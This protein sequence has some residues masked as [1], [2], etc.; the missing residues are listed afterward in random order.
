[1]TLGQKLRNIRDE[2]RLSVNKSLSEW[3]DKNMDAL[4]GC[5]QLGCDCIEFENANDF[6]FWRDITDKNELLVKDFLED[7]EIEVEIDYESKK[8]T[9]SWNELFCKG[10]VNE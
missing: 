8:I 4:I 2:E 7:E 9:I 6:A 1:M 10:E 3:F 5:A